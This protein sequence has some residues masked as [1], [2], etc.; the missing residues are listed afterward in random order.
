MAELTREQK[1]ELLALLE[2]KEARRKREK[3][4]FHPNPGQKPIMESDARWRFIFSG[5]G[6]WAPGTLIR[7]FDGSLKA[8]EDIRLGDNLMGPDSTPREVRKLYAGVEDMYTIRPK[9]SA[10]YQVNASHALSIYYWQG[11]S[12]SAELKYA[13]PTV[14]EF[15][16]WPKEKQR[17]SYQWRPEA[18]I[19]YSEADLEIPP[20]VLG[21]W[22]GDGHSAC[23]GLT[24]MD[25][26]ILEEFEAFLGPYTRKNQIEGNKAASYF[27]P[28]NPKRQAFAGL[29]NNKHIPHNYLVA[30]TEQRLELLA[31]LLD[32]DGH[33]SGNRY[34]ITQKREGLAAS[35]RELAQSLG[36]QTSI[37]PKEVNGTTYH[38]V[39]IWGPTQALPVRLNYKQVHDHPR[40]RA[41]WKEPF[42]V[43]PAVSGE[44]YG[45]QV[46]KD[47]LIL[48]S[49]YSV[50]RNSGKSTV[51][52]N[53]V[54]YAA[55]GYNPVTKKYSPV[56]A[57]I[58]LVLDNPEKVNDF[59]R[60]YR[61]W[62]EL[63]ADWCS[64]RGKPTISFI[65]YDTGSTVTVLSHGVEPLK[66]EGSQWD[67]V[68]FDEPPPKHVF[69]GIVRGLR[70]KGRPNKLLMAGTPISEAWLRTEIYEPWARGEM[71]YVACFKGSTYDNIDNLGAEE[72]EAFSKS[73]SEQEQ[74]TRLHGDFFSLD[75][76]ALAHLW[77]RAVHIIPDAE[78]DW[79]PDWP[80]VVAIDP[81]PAK[82]HHALMLGVD[83]DNRLYAIRHTRRKA[84]P[85]NFA[86]HLK[87]W[88]SQYRVIDIVCDSLG[89]ADMTG[90]E[91]FKSFIQVLRENGVRCRP[92]TYEEKQ[93]EAFIERIRSA[94]EIPDEPDNYGH[95]IPKLRVLASCTEVVSG[96]ENV[97]W[98]RDRR[99]QE[100]K[101]KLDIQHLD[102]VACLKYA[103]ACNLYQG[104]Q[105]VKAY[106]RKSSV[107][108]MKTQS[109]RKAAR[110]GRMIYGTSK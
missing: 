38:R 33:R 48:L 88:M 5:N 66:L 18:G 57:K 92:T 23:L 12:T 20:Y 62:H 79:D 25:Q 21:A 45:F 85:I 15:L 24:T 54:H 99:L 108:G 53:E 11:T 63:P 77:D 98:V 73:L 32:T 10:P 31:G 105:R 50:Q 109:Q 96:I 3:A 16:E 40:Q 35:I 84:T 93:D 71:P 86:T 17:R 52:A 91:G 74:R 78:F 107:Y 7:M 36:F 44:F 94:L 103:L 87:E 1:L 89:S 51:L 68:F 80:V 106:H 59:L 28:R 110:I 97:G 82:A 83:R 30:S 2:E 81:H 49:D 102:A 26:E 65:E 69:T 47:H 70:R 43:E 37:G 13:E 19:K 27:W 46:D 29:L 101:P 95:R 104:K 56:P 61:T 39:R 75:G 100:N 55:V 72:I 4:T 6:C 76:L 14:R 58:A 8:V 34:E 9:F 64:Q 42:T 60:E 22:L 90:G 67:Y 41:H